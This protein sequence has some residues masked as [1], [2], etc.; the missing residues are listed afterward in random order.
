MNWNIFILPKLHFFLK[1]KFSYSNTFENPYGWN[2]YFRIG[3]T[4]RFYKYAWIYP[5]VGTNKFE[6]TV[7]NSKTLTIPGF[8]E[9]D[10]RSTSASKINMNSISSV[11]AEFIFLT[12]LLSFRAHLLVAVYRDTVRLKRYF[13]SVLKW[14]W[15]NTGPQRCGS[16][17]LRSAFKSQG[18]TR[19]KLRDLFVSLEAVAVVSMIKPGL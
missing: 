7:K 15:N 19:G 5:K 18:K 12:P 9:F 16:D 4:S 11:L 1:M 6:Q 2:S 14:S 13:I 10:Y 8:S 3:I 17:V